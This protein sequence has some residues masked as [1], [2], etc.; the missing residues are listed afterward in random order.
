M[1]VIVTGGYGFVGSKI[2][3]RL[4]KEGHEVVVLEHPGSKRPSDFPKSEIILCDITSESEVANISIESVDAVLHLAAQS[5]GP[6]S[7][8]IPEVDLDINIFGTL[9]M[10]KMCHKNL[11]PR[12][13]FAS[14]FVVYGDGDG[15]S[16]CKETDPTF[17]KSIYATSKLAC[18]HLLKNYAEPLGIKW[19]ALRMFNI[20]GP[21]QDLCRQDQGL[22]AIFLGNILKSNELVVNGSL[23]RYRDL[24]YIDD[25]V[26]GWMA[27]LN[28]KDCANGIYNLASGQKITFK[29]LINLLVEYCGKGDFKIIESGSTQGDILGCYADVLKI[30][31]EIGFSPKYT[32]EIGIAAFV[33]WAKKG[34]KGFY[35]E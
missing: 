25:V 28:S 4:F 3:E 31:Q 16:S 7:F 33:K 23:D 5:S 9:N 27:C 2:T 24:V 14:S 21:G 18:E 29:R 26:E 8:S 12:I 20:Y 19:N 13:L 30:K 1:K 32:P 34:N 17:P 11:I 22:V 6:K 15:H 35:A 10:I